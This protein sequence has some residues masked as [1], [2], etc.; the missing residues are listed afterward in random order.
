M[1][2]DEVI[3]SLQSTG[4]DLISI[5]KEGVE[6]K[7]YF[8]PVCV[9]LYPDGRKEILY[10]RYKSVK[11]KEEAFNKMNKHIVDTGA[12]GAVF[13]IETNFFP[14]STSDL[15]PSSALFMTKRAFGFKEFE[16][17]MFSIE[18]G[19]TQ[20]SGV[21]G[22]SGAYEDHWIRAFSEVH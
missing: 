22:P 17:H 11:Q 6:G 20:W 2:R 19:D 9:V 8:D 5:A 16:A 1:E 7:G 14:N 10:P 21:V 3:R 13:I 12:I 4:G 15:P 18:E